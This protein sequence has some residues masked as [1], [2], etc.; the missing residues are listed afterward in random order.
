[1]EE[2]GVE[3]EDVVEDVVE[4]KGDSAEEKVVVAAKP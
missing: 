4:E 3:K 1:M 2:M